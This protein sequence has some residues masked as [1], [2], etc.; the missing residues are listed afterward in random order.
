MRRDGHI[1]SL[2][3]AARWP[4]ALAT[5][6][7]LSACATPIVLVSET[8]SFVAAGRNAGTAAAAFFER[9]RQRQLAANVLLV[10]SDPSCQW[11]QTI[12]LRG[13]FSD[14]TSLCVDKNATHALPYPI[15]SADETIAPALAEAV[16]ALAAYVGELGMLTDK[17]APRFTQAVADAGARLKTLQDALKAA[18]FEPATEAADAI[19]KATTDG[20]DAATAVA[21]MIDYL[22]GLAAVSQQADAVRRYVASDGAKVE[23]QIATL[24]E[25]V[26]AIQVGVVVTSGQVARNSIV[27]A[28][29]RK[30]RAMTDFQQRRDTLAQL[31]TAL[32]EQHRIDAGLA[33]T[34][35]MLSQLESQHRTLRGFVADKPT[36]Q[37]VAQVRKEQSDLVWD[38]I[39]RLG[40][41]AGAIGGVL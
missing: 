40:G 10:A 9:A 18:G 28:T 24:R 35:T 1:R 31:V 36:P 5:A 39:G 21:G 17:P 12:Y 26:K 32:E 19:G 14:G 8:Q 41:L 23:T 30:L 33:A 3:Q 7:L 29:N 38:V 27:I 11:A 37:Q 6:A 34:E 25:G 15:E 13:D 20:K 2:R 4:M 22:S 16:G